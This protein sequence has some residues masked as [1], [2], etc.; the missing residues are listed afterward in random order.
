MVRETE[1]KIDDKLAQ[2]RRDISFRDL[3]LLDI[4]DNEDT[5]YHLLDSLKDL[6]IKVEDVNNNNN[7]KGYSDTKYNKNQ[8]L[9]IYARNYIGFKNIDE[10]YEF[11]K[12]FNNE[13]YKDNPLYKL[14]SS[15]HNPLITVVIPSA[16]FVLSIVFLV[17]KIKNIF[18]GSFLKIIFY[19]FFCLII[20]FMIGELVIIIYHFKKYPSIHIDM[21]DKMKKILDLYN[22]RTMK[23][24]ICRIISLV[25]NFISLVFAII[26]L[27]I[28]GGSYQ[29]MQN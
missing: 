12:I 20:L 11:K 14:S 26:S 15:K 4:G 8:I 22:K 7:I 6:N 27:C 18:N 17:F 1:E 3:K 16:F 10:L 23:C 2:E 19:I 13:D 29:E 9:N 28:N 25:L 21:D 5:K 24:Q